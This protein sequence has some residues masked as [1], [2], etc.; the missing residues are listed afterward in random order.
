MFVFKIASMS[1]LFFIDIRYIWLSLSSC[2]IFFCSQT[3]GYYSF[4]C[5][6]K[7]SQPVHAWTS[8]YMDGRL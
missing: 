7:K 3:I 5:Y 1:A 4:H 2:L 8:I 6:P